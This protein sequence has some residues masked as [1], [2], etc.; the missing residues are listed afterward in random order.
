MKHA[1]ARTP[2]LTIPLDDYERHMALP[3]VGQAQLLGELLADAIHVH[4]P[5]SVA[6]LGCA[7]G[8]GFDCIP[9]NVERLVGVDINA[10]YVAVARR[11]FGVRRELELHVADLE[12]RAALCRR[13][14]RLRGVALRV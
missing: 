2:W 7:G 5:L 3:S 11:R 4:R 9:A 10:D 13:R 14:A 1:T 6:V 8:N 12:R